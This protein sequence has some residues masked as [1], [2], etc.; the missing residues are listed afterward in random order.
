MFDFGIVDIRITNEPWGPS[1]RVIFSGCA[2]YFDQDEEWWYAT[3]I[4]WW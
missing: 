2:V 1:A 3:G 4:L